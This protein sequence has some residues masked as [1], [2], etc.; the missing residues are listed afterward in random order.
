MCIND[1]SQ[2]VIGDKKLRASTH[3]CV[4]ND[5]NYDDLTI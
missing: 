5:S 3:S 2:K 4:I 1:G